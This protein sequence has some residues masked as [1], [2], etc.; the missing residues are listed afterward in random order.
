MPKVDEVH[1]KNT[2]QMPADEHDTRYDNDARGWVRGTTGTKEPEGKNET[3]MD[4]PGGFD[5]GNAWR[6]G[7]GL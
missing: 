1:N 7:R 2:N 5:R 6:R 3:G 4:Y